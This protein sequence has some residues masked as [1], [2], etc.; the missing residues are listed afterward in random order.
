MVMNSDNSSST[1]WKKVRI[2]LLSIFG[3]F[4][5]IVIYAFI[6]FDISGSSSFS[7]RDDLFEE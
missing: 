4:V 1:N 5:I 6:T 2:I 7:L 3:L